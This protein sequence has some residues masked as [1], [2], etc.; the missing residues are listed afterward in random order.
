ML[1]AHQRT[2]GSTKIVVTGIST[3]LGL[4]LA[5]RVVRHDLPPARAACVRTPA[6]VPGRS[7]RLIECELEV[8]FLARIMISGTV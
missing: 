2:N 6:T 4:V 7:P 3:T 1:A 8:A 5:P